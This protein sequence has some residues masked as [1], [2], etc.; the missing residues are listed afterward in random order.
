MTTRV[1]ICNDGPDV[2]TVR[3]VSTD[4]MK[5]NGDLCVS[6]NVLVKPGTFVDEYVH[7]G[8]QIIVDEDHASDKKPV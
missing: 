1:R 3:A 5:R 8:Q 2:V 6:K 4:L 7:T